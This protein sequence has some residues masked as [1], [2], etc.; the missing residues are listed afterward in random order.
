MIGENQ[1]WPSPGGLVSVR[2]PMKKIDRLGMPKVTL[3]A[4]S[5][6]SGL[7]GRWNRSPSSKVAPLISP[8]FSL[9]YSHWARITFSGP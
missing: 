9:Q 8:N 1:M 7:S 3:C 4:F 6:S 5:M 2:A